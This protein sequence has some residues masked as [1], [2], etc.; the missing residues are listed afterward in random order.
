LYRKVDITS[1]TFTI[2]LARELRERLKK[3]RVRWSNEVR[4]FIEERVKHPEFL[5]TIEEIESRAE[6]RQ[7]KVD[8]IQ[9]IRDDGERRAQFLGCDHNL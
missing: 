1:S 2:R 9:L 7:L 5:E 3:I 4:A 6:K 8:S